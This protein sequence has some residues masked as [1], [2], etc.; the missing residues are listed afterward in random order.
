MDIDGNSAE[1]KDGPKVLIDLVIF[2]SFQ[3]APKSRRYIEILILNQNR[4]L[5]I[6]KARAYC[7][8]NVLNF[9]ISRFENN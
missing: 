5:C 6:F 3:F 4:H 8:K 2:Y 9:F 1:D 7:E